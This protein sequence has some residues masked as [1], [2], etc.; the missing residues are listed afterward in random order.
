[1]IGHKAQSDKCTLHVTNPFYTPLC[2]IPTLL[3]PDPLLL[4]IPS[5]ILQ[6]PL[7]ITQILV[8]GPLVC[9]LISYKVQVAVSK[10]A[11]GALQWPINQ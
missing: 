6:S 11:P 5:Y 7:Q 3:L 2:L 4:I 10:A 8:G 1:M 9:L